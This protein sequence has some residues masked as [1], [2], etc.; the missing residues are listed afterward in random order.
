MLQH[1]TCLSSEFQILI[2]YAFAHTEF[3]YLTYHYDC[4]GLSTILMSGN[5]TAYPN[6][7]AK[8]TA[9]FSVLSDT[10]NSVKS[11]LD[12]T[13]GENKQD[14]GRHEMS[15]FIS[16][17]QKCESEKLNLTAALHLE[18]LR[19]SNLR[20]GDGNGKCNQVATKLLTKGIRSLEQKIA[21]VIE[22]INEVL[23]ELRCI[24]LE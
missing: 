9:S 18:R 24:S 12:E 10:I 5:I 3:K 14:N 15:N 21:L 17:L 19:L 6:L 20:L 7:C 2:P 4:R 16:Q 11:S 23:D 1:I 22:S 13:D 8:V